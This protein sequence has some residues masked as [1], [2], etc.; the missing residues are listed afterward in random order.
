MVIDLNS[1]DVG[2]LV[3]PYLEAMLFAVLLL[4]YLLLLFFFF[5]CNFMSC[6][7]LC[8]TFRSGLNLEV[9]DEIPVWEQVISVYRYFAKRNLRLFCKLLLLLLRS[10]S[11][12][13]NVTA[14]TFNKHISAV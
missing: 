11:R 10:K 3:V 6:V 8:C 4:L 7:I 12:R 1:Q 14:S 13:K 9:T 2:M 5:S